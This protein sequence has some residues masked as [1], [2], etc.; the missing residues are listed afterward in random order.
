MLAPAGMSTVLLAC[1]S[2]MLHG[3]A[4]DDLRQSMRQSFARCRQ[5]ST[6]G[7]GSGGSLI[8]HIHGRDAAWRGSSVARE[9]GQLRSVQPC[10]V[11]SRASA[12]FRSLLLVSRNQAQFRT[13]GE[14]GLP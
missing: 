14:T 8:R 3:G 5:L 6:G 9:A 13:L 11:W 1:S 4:V 12:L 7:R 10:G 2:M